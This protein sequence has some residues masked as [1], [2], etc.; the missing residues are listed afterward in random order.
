[1]KDSKLFLAKDISEII[2]ETDEENPVTIA[3]IGDV[4]SSEA[5]Y[6][7]RVRFEDDV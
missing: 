1:M 4:L 6:R 3:T 2:I 5:G 7:I